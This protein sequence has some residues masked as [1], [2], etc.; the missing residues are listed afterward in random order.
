M[1]KKSELSSRLSATAK[2]VNVVA[3]IVALIPRK[4]TVSPPTSLPIWSELSNLMEADIDRTWTEV[5]VRRPIG[6]I[7]T[8]RSRFA[9]LRRFLAL[10]A[11]L[12]W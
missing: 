12:I 7:P 8:T 5:G 3:A 2:L 9:A 1:P 4:T 10:T 6:R 11:T